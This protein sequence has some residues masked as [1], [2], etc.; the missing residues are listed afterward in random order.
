[1]EKSSFQW[2]RAEKVRNDPLTDQR[3]VKHG[4][5]AKLARGLLNAVK[6]HRPPMTCQR[7]TYA[8]YQIFTATTSG[9]FTITLNGVDTI[10]AFTVSQTATASAAVAA[11]NALTANALSYGGRN[12]E[13]D[14]RQATI[15]LTSCAPGTVFDICGQRITAVSKAADNSSQ[16]EISGS[17]TADAAALVAAI[18]AHPVLQDLVAADNSS[19]VVTVR[20][21]RASTPA[22]DLAISASAEVV[23]VPV[24]TAS[25]VVTVSSVRKGQPGNSITTAV[26]GTGSAVGGARMTAG[27][28]TYETL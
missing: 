14:N 8:A 2:L 6:G 18:K 25:T 15:T 22:R 21:R 10:T 1:M 12:I 20:S 23:S 24:L 19:G 7:D 27:T 17:D 4:K 5:Y 3:I 13:A 9:D 28:T 11:L 16:F 26:S